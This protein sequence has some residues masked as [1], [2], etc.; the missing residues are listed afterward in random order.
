MNRI[1]TEDELRTRK[2]K[3]NEWLEIC[4]TYSL[5]VIDRN[6]DL[7]KSH[8][9]A[10]IWNR[11]DLTENFI[12]K[13]MEN[14]TDK[15]MNIILRKKKLSESFIEKNKKKITNDMWKYLSINQDFSESFI[16]DNI[17]KL[18]NDKY[19]Y[20]DSYDIE[21]IK[22][23]KSDKCLRAMIEKKIGLKTELWKDILRN[24]SMEQDT[25][26]LL[27]YK[28][29]TEISYSNDIFNN[30]FTYQQ[31][32]INFVKKYI[33]KITKTSSWN[34]IFRLFELLQDFEQLI[35]SNKN[36]IDWDSL[37]ESRTLSVDFIEIN[38][39]IIPDVNYFTLLCNYKSCSLSTIQRILDIKPNLFTFVITNF[40]NIISENFLSKNISHI[41]DWKYIFTNFTITESFMDLHS[42]AIKDWD[43][44]WKNTK[45]SESFI[46]KYS[47]FIRHWDLIWIHQYISLDFL[48]TYKNKLSNPRLIEK[49]QTHIPYSSIN[50]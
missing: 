23:I 7:I 25:I 29:A 49:Y 15:W 32:N 46:I 26:E 44:F 14:I 3:F 42:Y 18:V 36:N 43:S 28:L 24:C 30:I 8:M 37:L 34:S 40:H 17:D 16:C 4:R 10:D 31:Y 13:H 5:E 12:E 11:N 39:S 47:H 45:V 22:K 9:W 48:L 38:L 41:L 35:L 27:V 20:K 19:C 33:S 6:I 1:Y 21:F 50:L 2:I